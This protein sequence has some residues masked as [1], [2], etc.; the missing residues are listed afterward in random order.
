[1]KPGK[2]VGLRPKVDKHEA[3]QL[4]LFEELDRVTGGPEMLFDLGQA[5]N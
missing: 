2:K 4:L 1:M 5:I 3:D